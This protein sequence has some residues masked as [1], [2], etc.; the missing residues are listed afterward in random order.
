MHG[1]TKWRD[2]QAKNLHCAALIECMGLPGS[3]KT[4][5][6][7]ILQKELVAEGL[8]LHDKCTQISDM[9]F[10]ERFL[11]KLRLLLFAII[12]RPRL[13]F[14]LGRWIF[15]QNIV[16]KA[17]KLNLAFNGLSMISLYKKRNAIILLDQGLIQIFWAAAR[18]IL[19]HGQKVRN[20]EAAESILSSLYGS[21]PIVVIEI[22][23]DAKCHEE[24]LA[25]RE[26][27]TPQDTAAWQAIL[28]IQNGAMGIVKNLAGRLA[29]VGKCQIMTHYV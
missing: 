12:I 7:K 26:G 11:F 3:G 8:Q 16:S 21:R 25:A 29:K 15:Q 9:K 4:T 22:T 17:F 20:L 13:S 5:F 14:S 28:P 19:Q 1:T 18:E 2:A 27:W 24:Q 10:G 6:C 23:A